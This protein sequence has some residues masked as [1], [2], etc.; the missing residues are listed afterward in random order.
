MFINISKGFFPQ[1]DTG[2]LNGSILADQDT[3]FDAMNLRL[4]QMNK[5]V[6]ADPGVQS[7]ASFTGGGGGLNT[8]RMFIT[9]KPL[10]QRKSADLVI[11]DLRPKLARIPGATLYLSSNQDLVIGGRQ[12]NALYQYTLQSDTFS[13]VAEWAPKLLAEL[14]KIPILVDVNSDQQNLGLQSELEYDRDMASRFGI[15]ASLLDNTLYDAFG[16]RQVS[17]MFTSLNQYHV[18]ME[19]A[20]KY[21]LNPEGLRNIYVTSAQGQQVPLSALAHYG[22]TTAPLTVSHQGPFS[23][24]TI[25]FNLQPGA[26]LGDAV[27][28]INAAKEKI[29]FPES[30]R[31]GFQGNAQAYQASLAMNPS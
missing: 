12:G 10:A 18:V 1:Q 8:A 15:S 11:A 24:V 17:T 19:A 6:M 25:S 14:K 5:I 22:S 31:G 4:Q 29:S 21:G 9:L 30:V 28:A 16:Q 27:D 26:A 3:S 7:I 23:A 2:R 13:E 20:P